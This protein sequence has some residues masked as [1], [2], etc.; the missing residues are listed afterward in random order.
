MAEVTPK[1]ESQMYQGMEAASTERS[2]VALSGR[3]PGARVNDDTEAIAD[4]PQ[5]LYITTLR[6]L[7]NQVVTA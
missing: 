6:L 3:F 4:L 2:S 1:A 7:E 5:C